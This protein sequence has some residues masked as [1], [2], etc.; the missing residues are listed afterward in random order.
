MLAPRNGTWADET[1]LSASLTQ[2]QTR[3][4]CFSFLLNMTCFYSTVLRPSFLFGRCDMI[5]EDLPSASCIKLLFM[6]TDSLPLPW[7]INLDTTSTDGSALNTSL[8]FNFQNLKYNI[9]SVPVGVSYIQQIKCFQ[10]AALNIYQ[11]AI[12]SLVLDHKAIFKL[13]L[14]LFSL[15]SDILETIQ[16]KIN[17]GWM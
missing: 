2:S 15:L 14:K 9:K 6:M 7:K 13:S 5:T 4:V 12:N 11:S 16:Q 17:S 10:K 3:W 8:G 1:H